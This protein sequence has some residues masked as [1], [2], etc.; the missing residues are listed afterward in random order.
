MPIE[1]AVP[2][3]IEIEPEIKRRGLG[4][5]QGDE[6][7]RPRIEL[8]VGDDLEA[9]GLAEGR[10]AAAIIVI[11]VRG[12]PRAGNLGRIE[13]LRVDEVRGNREVVAQEVG[14]GE[15]ARHGFGAGPGQGRLG[16][17]PGGGC[18]LGDTHGG[19]LAARDTEKGDGHKGHH[20]QHDQ[21]DDE[22]DAA[23]GLGFHRYWA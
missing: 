12:I 21:G 20:R 15:H 4:R 14:A 16:H 17:E 19:T 23:L 7:G 2:V 13:T 8:E 9:V 3:Q 22:R 6:D 5:V 11:D 10:A 1:D 18:L